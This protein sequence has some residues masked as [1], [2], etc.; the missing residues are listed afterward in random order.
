MPPRPLCCGNGVA[1]Q[2]D[3]LFMNHAALDR[4]SR[5]N[6][7][8]RSIKVLASER[9][10]D[11]EELVTPDDLW[12]DRKT[13]DIYVTEILVNRV[14]RIS[15]DGTRTTIVAGFA[16]G[17][18]HP[19]AITGLRRKGEDLRLFITMVS[20]E[21]DSKT[22]IY[23]I[24]PQRRF[25]PRL[26][27]G[28]AG[29]QV[30]YGHGMRAPNAMEFDRRGRRLYVPETY[31]GNVYAVDVDEHTA[32]LVYR[33]R[34]KTTN[35][36]AVR[37]ARDGS[38]LYAEQSSG[39]LLRLDPKG[40]ASQEPE[41]IARLNPGI[42]GIA[43]HRDGR[44]FLSNFRFGGLSVVH[45]SGR[46]SQLFRLSLSLP[47]GV[48]PLEDGRI[49]VA[50]LGSLALVNPNRERRRL[51]RPKQFLRDNFDI[52]VGVATTGGC[53]VY[54]TGFFRGTLQ[55]VDVCEPSKP[56]TEIVRRRT[57]VAAWDIA[58]RDSE[59]WVTDATGSVYH[60]TG[61]NGADQARARLLLS[62]L[63]NPTGI[64]IGDGVLYVSESDGDQIRRIDPVTGATTG[65]ITGLDEP[66]GLAVEADGSIVV[67]EAGAGQLVRVRPDG[68]REVVLHDLK[69]N[70]RGIGPLA[71]VNFYSDV[72]LTARGDILVTLPKKG[73]LLE[74]SD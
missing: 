33:G 48:T 55:H 68:E 22:G 71:F 15:P 24:D 3:R 14:T 70:I 62:G 47:N 67:V 11:D 27:Y 57:F 58:A 52:A 42:D 53:D 73:S 31:G 34:S 20:F 54:A 8:T 26:V 40:P 4:I 2:G 35:A 37:F 64:A 44:I 23:E 19:N 30:I 21:P 46:V 49:A 29:G 18:A 12:I 63:A 7:D 25:P 74:V 16:D 28:A 36:T 5:I 60:V 56:H 51:S 17:T 50:D 45:N 39:R 59:L 10:P 65:V 9:D 66:E 6:V 32:R 38:L 69:T 61:V 13:G 1:L 72:A 41:V 43:E